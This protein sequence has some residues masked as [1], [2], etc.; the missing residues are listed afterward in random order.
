MTREKLLALADIR[1][2]EAVEELRTLSLD[3]DPME[4]AGSISG[5][6][7]ATGVALAAEHGAP[8]DI[9]ERAVQEKIED[10]YGTQK[11]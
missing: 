5:M 7:I 8:R 9:V 10:A 2:S 3:M 11:K 1:F 6:L 4:R